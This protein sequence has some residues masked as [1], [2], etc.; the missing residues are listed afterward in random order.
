MRNIKD[1]VNAFLPLL[2]T[3]Y[4]I[5]LGRKGVAVTLRIA[6]DKKDC[7]HLMGLQYLIDR[8]ELNRDR[9]K[10]FDEIVAGS[11]TTEQVES[12]DYK[13]K[14]EGR[15]NF[16][17]LLEKL[18]DSNDTVFKYNQR[19]NMYSMIS[20][21]YLMKNNKRDYYDVLGI[22]KSAT[23]DEI[24][25]AYKKMALKYHPDRNK[26]ADAEAKFKEINEAYSVLSDKD[27]K[28]KYDRFGFSGLDDNNIP[29]DFDDIFSSIFGMGN[30]F[31]MFN[32]EK[33]FTQQALYCSKM[34][35]YFWW[36]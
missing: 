8:P 30:S 12:S 17:P 5:V 9:G 25:K 14:I 4:E 2:N 31:G 33:T 21:D 23:E 35:K 36:K 20:A 34:K 18:L 11:I 19:I 28:E 1:C 26:E 15:V 7:F 29:A 10:V 24:K 32:P 13:K 22:N 16:L 27:K 3:E 6:F